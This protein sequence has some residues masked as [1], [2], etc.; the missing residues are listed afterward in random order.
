M[1]KRWG[2]VF[3]SFITLNLI[4]L[5]LGSVFYI[6]DGRNLGFKRAI[7]TEP[8]PAARGKGLKEE[9]VQ[10]LPRL[11]T[12]NGDRSFPEDTAVMPA[13]CRATAASSEERF[14][15]KFCRSKIIKVMK[16]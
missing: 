16:A 14:L 9:T 15:A 8:D 10:F 7:S 12:R 6:E 11:A 3:I 5:R 2:Q 13:V 1:P 4:A